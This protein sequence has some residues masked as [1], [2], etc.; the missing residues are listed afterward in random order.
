[1]KQIL[2]FIIGLIL[3]LCAFLSFA[4]IGIQNA[5]IRSDLTIHYLL[6]ALGFILMVIGII[7]MIQFVK[8]T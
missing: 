3:I 6:I 7:A 5:Q 4:A 2:Y 8:K 1:M